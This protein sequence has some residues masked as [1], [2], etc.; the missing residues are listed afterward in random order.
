M[1]LTVYIP[2]LLGGGAERVLCT[3]ANHW[4]TSGHE[5][6]AVTRPYDAPDFYRL[7]PLVTRSRAAAPLQQV[8]G[9]RYLLRVSSLRRAIA[10][11]R[12]DLVVSFMDISNVEV[13]LA[14]RGLGVPVIVSERCDPLGRR[15]PVHHALMRRLLYRHAELVVV[16]TETVRRWARFLPPERVVT[17]PNFVEPP[18]LAPTAVARE[19]LIVAVGRLTDQKGFD[20]LIPAFHRMARAAPGWKLVIVGEGA[21]R[22]AL[23]RQ[24][25]ALGLGARVE[26]PGITSDVPSYLR[27]AGMFVLSSRH[28]GFPNVLLEAMAWG[29]PVVATDCPSGPSD[30]VRHGHDGLLVPL[31][32]LGA[33][34][35]AMLRLCHAPDERARL[36]QNAPEVTAR[37]GRERILAIWDEL[38]GRCAAPQAA[39]RTD[40]SRRT[41]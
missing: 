9:A 29:T 21:R 39:R 19:P 37:F 22:A 18:P 38:C 15:I 24:I 35:A 28:E 1:R 26:L 41:N 36:G 16:Q 5:V 7:H 11:S 34:A 40:S 20:L 33:L 10:A 31:G 6:H 27:R 32:D 25:A 4:A 17:V 14:T 13:L 3:L 12:P 23:E 30:I 2:T 8:Q